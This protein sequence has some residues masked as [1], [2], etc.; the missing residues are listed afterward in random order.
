M[1][2]F[3]GTF[4]VVFAGFVFVGMS[5]ILARRSSTLVFSVSLAAIC[6]PLLVV[7]PTYAITEQI[8]QFTP[9]LSVLTL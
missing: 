1:N 8:P 3:L 2:A 7:H 4:R 9:L 6:L 5:K